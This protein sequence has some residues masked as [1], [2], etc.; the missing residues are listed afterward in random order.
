MRL[1][2]G[3]YDAPSRLS[4]RPKTRLSRRAIFSERLKFGNI[5]PERG[6]CIQNS[7]FKENV[8]CLRKLCLE[9]VV[10]AYFLKL[11]QWYKLPLDKE[12]IN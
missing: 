7:N 2:K 3:S 1:K 9:A 11:D 10:G 6:S 4:N 12:H 8:N 5:A